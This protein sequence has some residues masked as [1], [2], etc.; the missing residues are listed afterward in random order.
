MKRAAILLLLL[1]SAAVS[2]PQDGGL[3]TG[4]LWLSSWEWHSSEDCGG[5]PKY[6]LQLAEPGRITQILRYPA[7]GQSY[8]EAE[9]EP[10]NEREIY[11]RYTE[12]DAGSGETVEL[13]EDFNYI[14]KTGV[15]MEIRRLQ[16]SLYHEYALYVNE[17]G[18]VPDLVLLCSDFPVKPNLNRMAEGV[19]VVTLGVVF[20]ET[21]Q[22]VRIRTAPSVQAG[23]VKY[24]EPGAA[25]ELDYC[26]KGK[27]IR[28]IARTLE[29]ERVQRWT[30]YWYYVELYAAFGMTPRYGWMFGEL[31]T[32]SEEDVRQA[33]AY[34]RPWE[35]ESANY[36][37]SPESE[38]EG[39]EADP[40]MYEYD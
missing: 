22:N 2:R 32:F 6:K 35:E 1:F 24:L 11:L 3:T 20:G 7:A 27:Q 13:D 40:A 36:P 39:E 25:R 14:Y 18:V 8:L 29:R 31:I 37:G 30:D 33:E 28:V 38:P 17:I 16:D 26:P 12:Y 15:R 9:W 5:W 10:V 34:L 19:P 4:H 23:I 21:T